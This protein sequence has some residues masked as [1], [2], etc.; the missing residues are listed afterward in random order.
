MTVHLVAFD[1]ARSRSWALTWAS[2]SRCRYTG[3]LI[4]LNKQHTVL[5]D[6]AGNKLLLRAKVVLR[7][8]IL[9]MLC[10][11]KQTKEH[12]SILAVDA[13]AFIIHAGLLALGAKPGPG[14]P[15]YV[16]NTSRKRSANRP[17]L[18]EGDSLQVRL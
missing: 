8:G 13:K 4:P 3:K 18:P 7:D 15:G 2:P 11:P 16:P 17:P 6:R 12:E 9:E 5:L 10:C 1:Q 14:K